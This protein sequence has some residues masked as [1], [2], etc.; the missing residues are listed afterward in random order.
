MKSHHIES[1]LWCKKPV[2]SNVSPYCLGT[3]DG[4]VKKNMPG[5]LLSSDFE[6][7]PLYCMSVL[8]TQGRCNILLIEDLV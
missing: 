8:C 2:E 3:F 1:E 4:I 6:P 7:V 5:K